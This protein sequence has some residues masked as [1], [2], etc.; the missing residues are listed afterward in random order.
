MSSHQ[1]MSMHNQS[2]LQKELLAMSVAAATSMNAVKETDSQLMKS[3]KNKNSR[4]AYSQ[5]KSSSQQMQSSTRTK[6]GAYDNLGY[7]SL[8]ATDLLHSSG[9]SG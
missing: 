9:Y 6:D 7:G 5:N 1:A 8:K 3:K 4:N 2:N